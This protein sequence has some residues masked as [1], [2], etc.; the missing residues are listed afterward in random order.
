MVTAGDALYG[1]KL[2]QHKAGNLHTK[3]KSNYFTHLYF[4]L[5]RKSLKSLL[6]LIKI[7]R[8]KQNLKIKNEI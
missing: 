3:T 1:T 4:L 5:I 6:T 8:L 7:R 2:F